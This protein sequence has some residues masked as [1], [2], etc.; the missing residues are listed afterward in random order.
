MA[1]SGRDSACNMP[2]VIGDRATA[3]SSRTFHELMEMLVSY[4]ALRRTA[5]DVESELSDTK[6]E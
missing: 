1:L 4:P 6:K 5:S 2:G 3:C